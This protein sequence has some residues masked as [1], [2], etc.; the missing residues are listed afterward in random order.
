MRMCNCVRFSFFITRVQCGR[1]CD[2]Y[3]HFHQIIKLLEKE[4]IAWIEG[5]N[6]GTMLILLEEI[7]PKRLSFAGK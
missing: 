5:E 4:S 2:I 7:D 1:K 3:L 6:P